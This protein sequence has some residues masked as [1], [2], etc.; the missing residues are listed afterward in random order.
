M[1][2]TTY[3]SLCFG[4]VSAIGF[5]CANWMGPSFALLS[6]LSVA[7][8]ATSNAKTRKQP[9]AVIN[10][11]DKCVAHTITLFSM[12]DAFKHYN[13][14]T[15]GI[16]YYVYVTSLGWVT[17]M[18]KIGKH[19]EIPG[20]TGELYHCSTHVVSSLGCICLQMHQ[21]TQ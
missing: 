17:Y 10:Y 7:N 6:V 2:L 18:F 19:I 5:K 11:A 12:Y 3:T 15:I 13:K 4:L 14:N 20:R 21:L 1:L 8:H 9:N 16:Y